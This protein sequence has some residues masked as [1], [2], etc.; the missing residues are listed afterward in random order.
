MRTQLKSPVIR[1]VQ[2][3]CL[4]A[5]PPHL[6]TRDRAFHS[7][8]TMASHP[9]EKKNPKFGHLPLSTSG[10]QECA[11]TVRTWFAAGGIVKA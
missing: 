10:P 8:T 7:S 9:K 4:Q 5:S 1:R 6:T 2:S 11:L 3:K